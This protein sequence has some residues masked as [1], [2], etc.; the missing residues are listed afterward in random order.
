MLSLLISYLLFF[1]LTAIRD[2]A[3]CQ[4]TSAREDVVQ[5]A[6]NDELSLAE[7]AVQGLASHV[8]N[9]ASGIKPSVSGATRLCDG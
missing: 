3:R 4:H 6:A 5:E 8:S 2:C 9:H 1:S 7:V